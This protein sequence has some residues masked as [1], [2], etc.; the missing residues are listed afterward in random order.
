MAQKFLVHNGDTDVVLEFGDARNGA[1]LVRVNEDGPWRK[2]ELEQIGDTGLFLLLLDDKPLELYLERRRGGALVTIGRHTFT[3]AVE[4]W[5]QSFEDRDTT[6]EGP[7]G[8]LRITAPMTGL[9]V[10]VP[11]KV[12]DH[13]ESGDVVLVIESMK[14]DNELRSPTAG[15]ISSV[16]VAPGDRVKAGQLLAVIEA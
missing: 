9:V 12:G 4:R 1:T 16:D 8:T 6:A 2:A 3:F 13:V 5:R 14:M 11:R 10:D 15:T 7:S